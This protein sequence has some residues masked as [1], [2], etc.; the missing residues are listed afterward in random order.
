MSDAPGVL[1]VVATPIGNL[2]DITVRALETLRLVSR[3]AAEDTRRTRALLSH[4]G[5][6]GK[7][8]DSLHEHSSDASVARLTELIARGETVAL[9]TDAGTPVVSDPGEAL[10]RAC[11]D[12]G[13]QVVPIPGPSAVLTALVG[14][15]LGTGHGF[16]FVGFLPR[17]G[18]ERFAA[19]R[20]CAETA[21]PVV[22]FEAPGRVRGTLM[23]FARID[24]ER[25]ACVARE[26]T[27]LHEEFARGTVQSLSERDDWMGEVC[28]VLG[29]RQNVANERVVRIKQ[30][31]R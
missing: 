21:E 22:F 4:H 16:R 10:L 9:V 15:G 2:G 27:K 1:Y 31:P 7:P 25:P 14:S 24:P 13:I 5:I 12:A 6:S 11:I 20:M 3:V 30:G 17:E 18:P 8:V 26:L 29:A 19:L 28:V 23:D